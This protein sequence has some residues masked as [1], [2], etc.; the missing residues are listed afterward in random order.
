[1]GDEAT[2][3]V[4][5][6]LVVW[7][8]GHRAMWALPVDH[9]GA[10]KYVVN[11]LVKKLEEAGYGG[12]SLTLKSDQEPAIVALKRTRPYGDRR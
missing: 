1:M 10:D 5:N 7:D 9:K 3:G 12:V 8:D 11:W 4:P 6:I 2:D